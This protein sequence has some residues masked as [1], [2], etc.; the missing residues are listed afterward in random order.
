MP[1]R[2]SLTLI[3]AAAV[4]AAAACN[5]GTT[6]G[7]PVTPPPVRSLGTITGRVDGD[8]FSATFTPAG[9]SAA[10]VGNGSSGE[11]SPAIYGDATTAHVFGTITGI[12]DIPGTSRTW[13]INVAMRN[14][15]AYAIGSNYSTGNA[16]PPD[17]SGV[18]LVFTTLPIRT[19][20]QS[21]QSPCT[22]K[23]INQ[24]GAA[25]FSAP[26][27]PYFWYKS[28]P[29]AVQGAPGTDTT[30]D[31]VWKFQATPF[32]VPDTIHSFTFVLEVSAAWPPPNDAVWGNS[33]NWKTD[34]MPD[35]VSKP[36]W[37]PAFKQ[38][39]GGTVL[40]TEVFTAGTGLT[41]T[42]S[43]NTRSI[44]L[45][46]HD[47]LGTM[48]GHIDA[49]L[50][51]VNNSANTIQAL[52]GFAEPAGSGRKQVFVGIASNRV[53]FVT[54]TQ[55][56]GAWSVNGSTFAI[57]SGVFHTFRLRKLGIIDNHLCVDGVDV[58]QR[59]YAQLNNTTVDFQNTTVT[60]GMRGRNGTGAQAIWTAVTYQIGN[61][62]GSC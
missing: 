43:P 44:Y 18:F 21:C 22:I 35:T 28:R 45:A 62:G 39:N 1:N 7:I 33:Y 41:M 12:V 32:A 29:T 42:A 59:T 60:F 13:T 16:T 55:A 48:D 61:D 4:L 14:L 54:Y 25:N 27:Q 30:G 58:L 57:T 38:T 40:G 24:M 47:S 56:T 50:K 46:R 49:T 37:K 20:P 3:F 34:S 51:I 23:L 26:A 53:S 8:K 11:L 15:L 5:D 36:R 2:T 6:G 19:N 31:V 10:L 17:T 52:I 9:A